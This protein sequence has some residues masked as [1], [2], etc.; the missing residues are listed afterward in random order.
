MSRPDFF[1]LC[2]EKG[3]KKLAVSPPV[4]V[5]ARKTNTKKTRQE[6]LYCKVNLK[7]SSPQ[8]PVNNRDLKEEMSFLYNEYTN[9]NFGRFLTTGGI[10]EIKRHFPASVKEGNNAHV[11]FSG[12]KALEFA[13]FKSV[14]ELMKDK[15]HLSVEGLQ[16]IR[17]IKT[18]MN[19][20]RPM[21]TWAR[22]QLDQVRK[23][24]VS[25][26]QRGIHTAPTV[27]NNSAIKK[28]NNKLVPILKHSPASTKE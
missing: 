9:N 11:P 25:I 22:P 3:T 27:K 23:D 10:K 24:L 14:A 7:H 4:A 12:N 20:G 13:D 19:K 21:S 26:Q 15:G 2:S 16:Q 8:G 1:S 28:V 17:Q 5:S 18:G 6:K